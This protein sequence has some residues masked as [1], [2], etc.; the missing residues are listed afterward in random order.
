[1]NLEIRQYTK[2]CIG[3]VLDFERRLRQEEDFWGWEIDDEYV[4]QVTSSFDDPDFSKSISLLAYKD[5][6]VIGRID[7]TLIASHFDGSRKAYLDWICVLKSC[8]HLGV[9]QRLMQELRSELKRLNIDTLIGLTASNSDAQAFYS[10]LPNSVMKDTG[11]WI[12]IQ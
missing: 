5:G 4:R 6:L 7:S 1:M 10:K 11:I 9:A 8:R 3:D 2:D 12:D